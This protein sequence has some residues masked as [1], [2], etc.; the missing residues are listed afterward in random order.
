MST[1]SK[2]QNRLVGLFS[3]SP[4][5][6]FRRLYGTDEAMLYLIQNPRPQ[7]YSDSGT[8][9]APPSWIQLPSTQ[10]HLAQGLR[11]S[12]PT[13]AAPLKGQS[14]RLGLRKLLQLLFPLRTVFL[15]IALKTFSSRTLQPYQ[16]SAAPNRFP[17]TE[18]HR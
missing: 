11:L 13:R 16:R 10:R 18:R 4:D 8:V 12:L 5:C 3:L 15:R 14:R 17:L 1:G 2:L 7:F 9:P 6:P